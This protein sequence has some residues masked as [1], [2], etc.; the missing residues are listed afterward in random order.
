[1]NRIEPYVP[2]IVLLLVVVLHT[3]LVTRSDLANPSGGGM[4][5]FSN[6]DDATQR[7]IKATL[8]T[9]DSEWAATLDTHYDNVLNA[10]SALP[11]TQNLQKIGQRVLK[12]RW[13]Q[14]ETSHAIASSSPVKLALKVRAVR[15]ELFK[16]RYQA[17]QAVVTLK[18]VATLE[19][20][21]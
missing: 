18:R 2:A 20:N 12:D 21:P 13:V 5:M 14:G 4:A 7:H 19:V 1:M 10:A 16:S 11:T 9:L 8:I 15:I 6:L 3:F 17:G